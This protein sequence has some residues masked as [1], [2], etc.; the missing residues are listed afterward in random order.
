MSAIATALQM[1]D[2]AT[3]G[4]AGNRLKYTRR[5][6]VVTDGYGQMDT[7]DMDAI[8][9]KVNSDEVEL[10]LLYEYPLSHRK[11]RSLIICRGLDFDDPEMGFKEES[12]SAEKVCCARP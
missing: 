11:C 5:I 4:K 1:I 9:S 6:I 3:T 10:T 12:K 2:V 8:V 7:E